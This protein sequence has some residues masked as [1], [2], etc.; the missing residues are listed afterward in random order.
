LKLIV[1]SDGDDG[2]VKVNADVCLYAGL[3]NDD[4][5][6]A[7]LIDPCRKV[8]VHVVRGAITVNDVILSGG[9]AL[10]MS[11]EREVIVSNGQNAEVL[12]FDLKAN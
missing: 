2:S 7:L 4:Q 3:F 11:E 9:D 10:M 8:Y 5:Q 6:A 12:V 1:S